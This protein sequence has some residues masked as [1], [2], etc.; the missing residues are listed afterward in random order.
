MSRRKNSSSAPTPIPSLQEDFKAKTRNQANY[1]RSICE[2]DVTF[3]TG[4][5]G[6]GKSYCC[7]ALACK[8]LL[9]GA[10]DKIIIARPTIEASPR[11]IGYIKGDL[12]E[13]M[14][15]W[16][17]PAVELMKRF[18]GKD[19]Y[20]TLFH[21]EKIEFAPLEYMRGRTFLKTFAVLEE[22]QNCTTEQ[23]IMFVTRIGQ[24]TKIVINGD[25]DQTDLKRNGMEYATDLGY[26][27]GKLEDNPIKKFA[28]H[29]LTVEDIQRHEVIGPFLNLFK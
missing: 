7:I 26:V 8:A 27:I 29:H 23:L 5:A 24:G 3:C 18:L 1:I 28:V 19:M 15:P 21:H 14:A 17:L 25:T 16:V 6:T 22:A 10:V 13:K 20:N 12:T 9:E 2:N 11:G 4:S